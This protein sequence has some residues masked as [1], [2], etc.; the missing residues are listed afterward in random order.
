MKLSDFKVLTFD[1][2]GTLSDWESGIVAGLEPLTSRLRNA[3]TRDQIL[4]AHAFHESTTQSFTPAKDYASL[5]AVVYWRMAEEWEVP[6]TWEE[7]QQYGRTVMNWPAFPDSVEALQYLK[8]HFRLA[9]LSNTD[10]ESFA[11]SNRKLDVE[12][13]AVYLAADIGSYKPDPRNFEYML[14]NLARHGIEKHDILHVAE[15]MFH[16]H[17]PAN[18]FGLANCWI[19]RRHDQE[20]FGATMKPSEMPRY[21]MRFSSMAD[22]VKAHREE[23]AR[24]E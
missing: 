8:R 19:Y 23:L 22:L 20:G 21:D 16:D 2:Y 11:H 5:L 7:C 6:V 13:D 24:G 10:G 14:K 18:A 9:V 12:F 17:G 15:S 4:E 3:P 1:V